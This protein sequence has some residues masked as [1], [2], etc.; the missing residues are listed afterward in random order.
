V[1]ADVLEQV[2]ERTAGHHTTPELSA[3]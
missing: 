1:G 3:G 2:D